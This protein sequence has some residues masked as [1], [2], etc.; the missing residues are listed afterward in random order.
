MSFE[1]KTFPFSSGIIRVHMVCRRPRFGAAIIDQGTACSG[2]AG[3]G[4]GKSHSL[5]LFCLLRN[6]K[7]T[8]PE[9]EKRRQAL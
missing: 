6:L 3:G 8:V 9:G 1:K 2:V 4:E 7:S 5:E